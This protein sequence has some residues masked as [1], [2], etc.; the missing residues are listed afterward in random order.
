MNHDAWRELVIDPEAGPGPGPGPGPDLLT[1]Q[2]TCVRVNVS[3]ALY[4]AR[5]CARGV[6]MNK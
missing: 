2:P 4:A 5:L 3:R 6:K 1:N